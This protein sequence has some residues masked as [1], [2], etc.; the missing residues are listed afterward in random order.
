M[1]QPRALVLLGQHRVK[2][3]SQD[4]S[5]RRHLIPPVEECDGAFELV[6][7]IPQ[8]ERR[9]RMQRVPGRFDSRRVGGRHGRQFLTSGNRYG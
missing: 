4:C 6:A 5:C 3:G 1:G 9:Q 8:L 2:P 7:V